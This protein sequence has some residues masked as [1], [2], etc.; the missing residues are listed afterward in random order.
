MKSYTLKK[1]VVTENDVG[2]SIKDNFKT[3]STPKQISLHKNLLKSRK[4]YAK[5]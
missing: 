5:I 3:Y 1:V 2:I 4:L